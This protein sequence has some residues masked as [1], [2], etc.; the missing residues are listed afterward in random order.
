M[1]ELNRRCF[2][3]FRKTLGSYINSLLSLKIV[4]HFLLMLV[5]CHSRT[6]FTL[7]WS[8]VLLF[9]D[10]KWKL[11]SDTP[12]H[13]P[14]LCSASQQGKYRAEG[15]QPWFSLCI[16]K[17]NICIIVLKTDCLSKHYG[18]LPPS[19]PLGW[20]GKC[21]CIRGWVQCL[22]KDTSQR[23]KDRRKEGKEEERGRKGR[24]TG[25][26]AQAQTKRWGAELSSTLSSLGS[27]K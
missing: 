1:K 11:S 7:L 14:L 6:A 19:S 16:E 25:F 12:S 22:L 23:L 27:L 10:S 9:K 26:H 17:T 2:Q 18:V 5:P 24:Q 20:G 3:A 4:C 21:L 13:L 8:G 15:G